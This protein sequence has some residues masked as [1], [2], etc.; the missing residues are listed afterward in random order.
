MSNETYNNGILSLTTQLRHAF[1]ILLTITLIQIHYSIKIISS[2]FYR[3]MSAITKISN[4]LNE[5]TE[6]TE[7][8][9]QDKRAALQPYFDMFRKNCIISAD[10]SVSTIFNKM[11]KCF[12]DTEYIEFNL[13]KVH[14]SIT[15]T[16]IKLDKKASYTLYNIGFVRSYIIDMSEQI[17]ELLKVDPTDT[18]IIKSNITLNELVS[19]ISYKKETASFANFEFNTSGS[20]FSLTIFTIIMQWIVFSFLRQ[21]TISANQGCHLSNSILFLH[22]NFLSQLISYILI[23]LPPFAIAISLFAFEMETDF[24]KYYLK[25]YSGFDDVIYFGFGYIVIFIISLISSIGLL[26]SIKY[27]RNKLVYKKSKIKN[28]YF[29]LM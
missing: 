11:Q 4:T 22:K 27:A 8:M 25:N 23:L 18:P 15:K 28:S 14:N 29:H 12:D 1:L 7:L 2:D 16:G 19:S 10:E 21:L 20:L 13:D 17:E 26:I 5:I 3:D 6:L 24:V 9:N